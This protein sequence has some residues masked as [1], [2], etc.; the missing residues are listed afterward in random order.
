M[1]KRASPTVVGTFVVVAVALAVIAVVVLGGGRY[2]RD[3]QKLV[4]YFRSSVNGL[5]VGAPVKFKGIQI[6]EVEQIRI[7]ISQLQEEPDEM[8]I[9]VVLE[10]D[11]ERLSSEGVDIDLGDPKMLGGLID[12][13]LRAELANESIV[14]GVRYVALDMKPDTEVDL[15]DDPTVDHPEVPAVP[16]ATEQIQDDIVAIADGLASVDY[17]GLGQSVSGLATSL[18][19]VADSVKGVT[20]GEL[21]VQMQEALSEIEEAARSIR[22]LA[23]Q[24]SRD[25]GSL[26]RGGRQ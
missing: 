24:I 14:T 1:S 12:R 22:L 19:G 20:E 10:I 13:G 3:T 11:E 23:D 5:R 16:V 6:G 8:R 15:V 2:F 21:T 25:P 17:K 9:P 18:R 26:I 7:S 4:V